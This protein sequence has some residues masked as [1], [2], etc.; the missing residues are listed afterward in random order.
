M[1]TVKFK[2][3]LEQFKETMQEFIINASVLIFKKIKQKIENIKGGHLAN[4]NAKVTTLSKVLVF[5][6]T[7]DS[8]NNRNYING[9]NILS[10]L[11]IEKN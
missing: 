11:A 8:L 6:Q 7:G 2:I 10:V 1:V 3:I 5:I 9:H 4:F